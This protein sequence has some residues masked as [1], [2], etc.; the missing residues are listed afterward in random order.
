MATVMPLTTPAYAV[1][2]LECNRKKLLA[3][4]DEQVT[5][6]LAHYNKA[7]QEGWLHPGMYRGLNGELVTLLHAC[8][9]AADKDKKPMP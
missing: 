7:A 4:L 2:A 8:M 9:R 3:E 5:M 1:S 6:T